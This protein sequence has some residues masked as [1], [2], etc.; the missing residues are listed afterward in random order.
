MLFANVRPL[1]STANYPDNLTSKGGEK[2]SRTRETTFL[3]EAG[4]EVAK[5]R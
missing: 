5:P 2:I 4:I 3:G 1:A